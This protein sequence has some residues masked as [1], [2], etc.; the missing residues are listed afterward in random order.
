MT[1]LTFQSANAPTMIAPATSVAV[2]ARRAV[3]PISEGSC[4]LRRSLQPMLERPGEHVY[5]DARRHAVVLVRPLARAVALA[6]LGTLGFAIGWPASV[7][8]GVLLVVGAGGAG[9][10]GGGR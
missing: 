7:A 8:G 1:T 10:G 3:V 4:P 9:G 2:A 6:L 5:L